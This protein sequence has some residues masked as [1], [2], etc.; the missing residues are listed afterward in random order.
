MNLRMADMDSYT[1]YKHTSPSGKVYIG[2]TKQKPQ[3]RFANGIGYK[4]CPRF[5][6]A[7]QKYGWDQFSHEVLAEGLCKNAAEAEEIRLIK[8]YKSNQRNL[9]YNIDN[10]GNVCGTHAEET[11][12]KI[13]IANKGRVRSPEE[14]KRIRAAHKGIW[15]RLPNPFTGKHHTKKCKRDQAERMKGNQYFKDHHHT[16]EFKKQKSIE[17]S[18]KYSNGGNPKCKKVERISDDGSTVVFYS[19][20]EAARQTSRSPSAICKHIKNGKP[21]DGAVWRY[22][23]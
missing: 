23:T 22:C 12:R 6:N 19:L 9:G 2:I 5:W 14:I 20:Q 15:E 21:L 18:A 17:M 3:K 1:V 13:S 16:E 8:L 4:G 7:I 10:G 11:R